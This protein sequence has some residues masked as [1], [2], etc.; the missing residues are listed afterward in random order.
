[1][2]R[3]QANFS[4]ASQ[5]HLPSKMQIIKMLLKFLWWS[6]DSSAC[7]SGFIINEY[8]FDFVTSFVMEVMFLVA[9]Y[10]CLSVCLLATLLKML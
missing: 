10:F 8:E 2:Q 5:K 7:S 6:C 9:L 4:S 1:M 3:C